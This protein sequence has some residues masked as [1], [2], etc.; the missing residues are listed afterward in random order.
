MSRIAIIGSGIGGL[1][2][3]LALRDHGFDPV[4]YEAADEL[5]PVGSGIGI[6]PN[7]MQALDRLDVAAAIIARGVT[8]DQMEIRTANG[9]TLT[10][11]DLNDHTARIGLDHNLMAIHRA[12]LQ[13]VLA[14]RLPAEVLQLGR[15]CIDVNADQPVI[16][17]AD[18]TEIS[19]DLIIGADGVNSTVRASLFPNISPQY[20]GDVAYRGLVETTIPTDADRIGQKSGAADYASDTLL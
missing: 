12:E 4:V 5:R 3:A 1:C 14:N 7:G 8:L 6:T 9:Q 10:S 20:A 11:M 17:F 18:G 15:E 19:A 16:H 13:A 2:T